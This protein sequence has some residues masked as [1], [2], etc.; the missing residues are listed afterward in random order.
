SSAVDR[1]LIDGT[2][3]V[4]R[5]AY[6]RNL[7]ASEQW[8]ADQLEGSVV[9][10]VDNL[11][12]TEDNV[13]DFAPIGRTPAI[14]VGSDSKVVLRNT[15]LNYPYSDVFVFCASHGDLAH[16]TKIWCSSAFTNPYDACVGIVD[17]NLLAHRIFYRGVIL[18]LGEAKMSS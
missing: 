7:E 11:T 17:M 9:I 18:E 1:I 3:R 8:V 16:L 13:S 5:L 2:I 12:V 4:S 15:V 14:K 6:Y 10:K